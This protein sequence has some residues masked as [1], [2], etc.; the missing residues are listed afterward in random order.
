MKSRYGGG[1]PSKISTEATW[2]CDGA[3]SSMCRNEVSRA[4]SRSFAMPAISSLGQR[5]CQL[6]RLLVI[7]PRDADA[8]QADRARRA[9]APEQVERDV[10]DDLFLVRRRRQRRRPGVR[11]EVVEPHLDP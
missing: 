5:E 9:E 7:Q 6:G 11:G 3:A 2:M 8:Q 4:V 10:R 1:S